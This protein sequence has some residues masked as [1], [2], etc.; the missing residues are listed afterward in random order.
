MC[1]TWIIGKRRNL[2][3]HGYSNDQLSDGFTKEEASRKKLCDILSG[4]SNIKLQQKERVKKEIKQIENNK[5]CSKKI[6]MLIQRVVCLEFKYLRLTSYGKTIGC[7][8]TGLPQLRWSTCKPEIFIN[9]WIVR[10]NLLFIN[11]LMKLN[12]WMG[13]LTNYQIECSIISVF[14]WQVHTKHAILKHICPRSIKQQ[15]YV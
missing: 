7:S 14:I 9:T 3:L 15:V 2:L 5:N 11:E 6:R 10:I 1:H 12:S 4:D 13:K 8:A